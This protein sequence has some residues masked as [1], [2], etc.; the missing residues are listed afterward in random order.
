MVEGA[1]FVC[2]TLLFSTTIVTAVVVV[3][4]VAVAVVVVAVVGVVAIETN[5]Y[6]T[7]TET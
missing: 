5:L 7:I 2:H 4:A 6:S 1:R 3:V